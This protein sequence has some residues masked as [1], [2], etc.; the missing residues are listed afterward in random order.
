METRMTSIRTA[1]VLPVAVVVLCALLGASTAHA[2]QNGKK[3]HQF[4]GKVE[5]VDAKA[6]TLLVQ[7]EKVDGWMGAMTMSYNVDREE[8]LKQVKAGDQITAT[9]R[10]GDFK[11]LYDVHV[12]PKGKSK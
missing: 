3:E 10:D 4:R 5:Q 2:Q 9:V 6:K 1:G 8:I 11:T 7:G 12:V